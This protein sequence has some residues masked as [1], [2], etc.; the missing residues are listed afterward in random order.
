MELISKNKLIK[1]IE[2]GIKQLE[3]SEKNIVPNELG[4][5]DIV[6]PCA[7]MLMKSMIE[8]VNMCDV[9]ESRP[10]GKWLIDDNYKIE[11]YGEYCYCQYCKEWT[12]NGRGMDK[13]N[14]CPNCG[15]EMRGDTE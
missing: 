2:L 11:L 14:Y 4:R 15:A 8:V 5:P 9:I 1:S 10:K 13:L 3:E 12:I 7:I 6:I